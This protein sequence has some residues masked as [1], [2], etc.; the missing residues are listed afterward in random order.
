MAG[1]TRDL[2]SF[3]IAT[4]SMRAGVEETAPTATTITTAKRTLTSVESVMSFRPT[5][6]FVEDCIQQNGVLDTLYQGFARTWSNDLADLAINGDGATGTFLS[7]N[8]GFRQLLIDEIGST[9]SYDTNG[10]TDWVDTVLPAVL[11]KLPDKYAN[12]PG[13]EFQVCRTDYEGIAKLVYS[14]ETVYG[15]LT[16]SSD[17]VLRYR[18]IPIVWYPYWPTGTIFLTDPKNL[19]MGIQRE[20]LAENDKDIE[21]R[22]YIFVMSGRTDF[23]IKNL[24]EIVIAYDIP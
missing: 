11:L 20:F 16:L 10:S 18:G 15:D 23:Q 3:D 24:G 12:K 21:K 1:P 19:V 9:N 4:R 5:Y 2:D 7:I 13:L 6:Q 14:R 22:Q 17:N 8:K